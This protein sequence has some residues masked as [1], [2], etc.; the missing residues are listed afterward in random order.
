M[1]D[2]KIARLSDTVLLHSARREAEM[3]LTEDPD[4]AHPD[5]TLL[6]QKVQMFWEKVEGAS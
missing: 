1:P 3:L 5:H 4:L 6:R 2:L